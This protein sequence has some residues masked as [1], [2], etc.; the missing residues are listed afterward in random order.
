MARSTVHGDEVCSAG[1]G[2]RDE[3]VRPAA[4]ASLTSVGAR[5]RKRHAPWVIVDSDLDADGKVPAYPL[6]RRAH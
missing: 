5:E 1:D 4:C 3:L 2:V 6:F